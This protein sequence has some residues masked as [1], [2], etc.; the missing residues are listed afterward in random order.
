MRKAAQTVGIDKLRLFPALWY[1]TT[2]RQQ[3]KPSTP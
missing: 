1:S 2:F 3:E